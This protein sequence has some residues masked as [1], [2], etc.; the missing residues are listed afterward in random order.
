MVLLALG[1]LVGVA[2]A[3][4][5]SAASSTKVAW[6]VS[7]L[8]PGEARNLSTVA[9]TNSPGLKSWSKS[10]TCTLAPKRKPT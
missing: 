2:V 10:G 3:S 9:S 1:V 5:V 6:N 4:P 7:S 8:M